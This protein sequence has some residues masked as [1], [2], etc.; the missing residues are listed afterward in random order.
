MALAGKRVLVVEDGPTLTHGEMPFG[1][2]SVAAERLGA[3]IVSPAPYAVG[4][5][6]DVF[7]RY[8]QAQNVLPAMGYSEAQVRDLEATIHAADVDA[9][10]IG[11][12]IDLR[13]VMQISVPAVRVRYELVC[14]S[15]PTLE[16]IIR[17]RL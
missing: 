10:V 8:P 15:R 14:L 3:T 11:T 6:R 1:A 16:D 2:G 7:A 5:I 17:E 13:R 4:S 12:P 9:V